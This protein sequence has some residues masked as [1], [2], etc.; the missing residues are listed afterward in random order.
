MVV[1]RGIG[2]GSPGGSGGGAGGGLPSSAG[3]G[4][5]AKGNDGDSTGTGG[6]IAGTDAMVSLAIA[7]S[8]GSGGHGGATLGM[9]GAVG[10]AG[11]GAIE[12]T[13]AGD[14]AITGALIA[15]GGKGGTGGN[16][17][18]GGGSGGAILVR[19]GKTITITTLT[20]IGGVAGGAGA[21]AGSVGRLRVDSIAPV[22]TTSTSTPYTGPMMTMYPAITFEKTPMVSVTGVA[23]APFTYFY[24]AEDGSIIGPVTKTLG[25]D[26]K[27]KFPLAMEL[28]RGLNHVCLLVDGATTQSP[29]EA[30]N[31]FDIAYL[32][33]P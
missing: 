6:P 28:A 18:G 23:L 15:N 19:G 3:G 11:G 4:F 14:L 21:G 33:K 8:G 13:A 2:N 31:C 9:A 25:T 29:A 24:A 26:G 22:S 12:I 20:N 1:S 17:P 5:K 10:G 32:Y 16:A 7:G 30:M 27:A